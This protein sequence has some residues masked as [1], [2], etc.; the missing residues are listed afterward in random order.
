MNKIVILRCYES[1]HIG[2][3]KHL[4]ILFGVPN[5]RCEVDSVLLSKYG[6]RCNSNSYDYLVIDESKFALFMLK[7]PE[8]IENI[9]H[10]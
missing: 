7:Y 5:Y 8:F 9:I 1:N 3:Y 4:H 6:I 2:S 10:E